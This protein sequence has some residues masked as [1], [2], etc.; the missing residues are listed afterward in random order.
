MTREKELLILIDNIRE[1]I[2][3]KYR[4]YK[5]YSNKHFISIYSEFLNLEEELRLYVKEYNSIKFKKDE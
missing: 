3:D 1:E 2:Q 5:S 4:Y